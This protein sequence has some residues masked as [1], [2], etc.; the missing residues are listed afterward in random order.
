MVNV[1]PTQRR[2]LLPAAKVEKQRASIIK[3]CES[4]NIP[5][6]L[7]QDVLAGV[8]SLGQDEDELPFDWDVTRLLNWDG[9]HLRALEMD[10]DEKACPPPHVY[11]YAVDRVILVKP[12]ADAANEF[13]LAQIL[14]HGEGDRVGEY[15]VRWYSCNRDYG[16]YHYSKNHRTV[17]A[18]DWIY[19]EAVQDSVTMIDGGKKLSAKSKRTVESFVERWDQEDAPR[20]AD[21]MMIE[22]DQM[23][24]EFD[25]SVLD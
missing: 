20:A 4:R 12:F 11:E 8:D 1:P 6:E 15:E 5:A 14:S 25:E 18:A 9:S 23:P 2:E 7:V 16:T 21:A 19:E 22:P 13:W 17:A 3:L 24:D 10:D